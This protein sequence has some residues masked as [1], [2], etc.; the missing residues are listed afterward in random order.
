M[1][2]KLNKLTVSFHVKDDLTSERAA[3]YKQVIVN[4]LEKHSTRC[5]HT[6]ELIDKM[7]NDCYRNT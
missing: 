1:S 5:S 6:R 4:A 3:E 2:D 7:L